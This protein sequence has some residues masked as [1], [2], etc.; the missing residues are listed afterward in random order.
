ML[1]QGPAECREPIL[2]S[3]VERSIDA[4]ALLEI[5]EELLPKGQAELDRSHLLAG[6][7]D[8]HDA[9]N[10]QSCHPALKTKHRLALRVGFNHGLA[11]RREIVAELLRLMNAQERERWR[12]VE[13]ELLYFIRLFQFTEPGTEIADQRCAIVTRHRLLHLRD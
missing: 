3:Q 2:V 6:M 5:L 12:L 1:S 9:T 8:G 7:R 11:E 4:T 10:A 13:L